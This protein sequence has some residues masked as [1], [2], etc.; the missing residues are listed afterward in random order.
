MFYAALGVWA[1]PRLGWVGMRA[2]TMGA[3]LVFP[4]GVAFVH[5]RLGNPPSLI[6]ITGLAIFV[7]ALV[8]QTG[9]D[10][11]VVAVLELAG[12][13]FLLAWFGTPL[14]PL[15][16]VAIVL[17]GSTL[18]GAV[19]GTMLL[20]YR[21]VL[22][23]SLLSMENALR[24]KSEFLNTMSH[25]LR[26]PLHVILGYTDI[27][28]DEVGGEELSFFTD[29][30]R[31]SALE[32]LHL[33]ENTMQVARLESGKARLHVQEFAAEDV[34]A[35]LSENVSAL[36]EAKSG[37]P[38]YWEVTPELPLVQLDRLKLKEI[39]QNLVSNALKFTREGSVSVAVSTDGEQLRIAVRDTG[40]GIPTES[41]ARIFEMFERV[42]DA[43]GPRVAGVG[44]GLYIVRSLVELM[45][46][47]VDVASTV[48]TGTCFTVCLPL[49]LAR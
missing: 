16:T 36:P 4:L 8:L 7:T 33:V 41:Q 24:A 47:R 35:E 43:N 23:E 15:E 27:L 40:P 5:G 48:G 31:T 22:H 19:I 30:I 10:L 14:A 9:W 20:A 45:Q 34:V 42:D 17:V 32:L 21:I 37:V 6:P 28:R 3:A 13:G 12:Q 2:Y 38:V 18:V 44:L 25:E 11:V 49:Q 26:S 1:I 29:R 46:G 39:V